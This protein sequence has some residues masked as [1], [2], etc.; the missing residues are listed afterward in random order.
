MA[1]FTHLHLH[2]QYSVLDGANE[3]KSLMKQVK[4]LGMDSVAITDH[5]NMYGV[6]EFHKAAKSND[7][8]P[9]LGCEAYVARRGLQL[10]ETKEDRSGEHII[11]LAKNETGYKN[12]MKIISVS[13][14]EG[15]YYKPR[16]DKELLF[17]HHDGIIVTT[18]CLGG[19]VPQAILKGDTKKAEQIASEYKAVFGDDYYLELQLH[20][21]EIN[22]PDIDTYERQ[23]EVNKVIMDISKK[24]DIKVVATNDVHFLKKEDAKAHNLLVRMNTKKT[25]SE[26]IKM[27]YTG[28]EY[29]KSPEEMAE[30]F[31]DIPE[32]LENTQEIKNKIEDFS[33]DKKPIMPHFE[34]PEGFETEADY[35]RHIVFE[36]A[37]KCWD[38]ITPEIE[39]RLN[40]EL[41][42]IIG[43]GFPGYFLIVW[44]F[45]KAAREMGVWVG[46]G[47]GSAAGSAVAYTLNIITVDPIKYG[48][49]FERFLNPDRISMPDIDID[50]DDDGREKILKW[51]VE[52]YGKERVANII[53]YGT[54]ASKSSIRD[55][56]RVLE[57]PLYD[58]DRLAKLVPDKVKNLEQAYAE[59]EELKTACE[60]S[61]KEAEVLRYAKL[62]EG[63]VRQ[64]GVHACGII[65][66]RDDLVEHIPVSTSKDADLLVTQFEGKHVEDVGLL[67]MDF[68]GLR[69][70]SIMKDAVANIKKQHG[71]DV[72]LASIPLDD[73]EVFALFTR[74][75]TTALFQFESDN[76]KKFLRMLKPTHFEDL[77]AMNA[78]YRPGPMQYIDSF[79]RRK[80]GKEK[81]TYDHPDM[82][83][84]LETTYGITVYQEQVMRLSRKMAGFTRGQADS[85]RKA[86]GKKIVAKMNELRPKFFEGCQKNGYSKELIT[87][88]WESWAEFAKYAFNRSHSVCY[89]YL[90]YQTAYLKAHYPPEF[91]AAALTRN[92]S[93][94]NK[95]QILMEETKRMGLEVNLPD[96]NQGYYD[97]Q[98]TKKG[99]N[100]GL[101]AIKGV[102]KSAVE[103]IVEERNNNGNFKD[104]Y[105]FV[106]R[107]NLNSVNKRTI[108]ALV[109]AGAFD[110][111]SGNIHRSAFFHK[112]HDTSPSFIEDTIRYG[113]SYQ[114]DGDTMQQSIFG[115]S[116]DVEILKP[117]PPEIEPWN[118]LERLNKEK[119]VIG[120]YLSEH[121]LDNYKLE[122]E[123]TC[124]PLAELTTNI[125]KYKGME[126]KTAGI[127]TGV[128]H[129][130]TKNGNPFG[131]FEYEDFSGNFKVTIFGKDYI[132][133]KNYMTKGFQVYIRGK[134]EHRFNKPDAELEY[135]ITKIDMLSE[136]KDKIFNKI[137][138]KLPVEEISGNFVDEFSNFVNT[139]SG[140]VDL[141]VIVYDPKSNVSV[142]MHSRSKKV[143][144]NNKFVNYLKQ[145]TF[146]EF[147][148]S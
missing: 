59:V 129:A 47:R 91:M 61:G 92:I 64:T 125:E 101:G 145:K 39:Q 34:L 9:I 127:I 140:N 66:S 30:L 49:L 106:E 98:V 117:T 121:P 134:V 33:L 6:K 69:T 112:T 11:L 148:I 131:S 85:L 83:E 71:I 115:G 41:D 128:R 29:L 109:L 45:L 80:H 68:L 75:E 97:F 32:A 21:S 74:G 5:G 120:I 70:L 7:I 62:L 107:V 31:P 86:M 46:P 26:K 52:K 43:M 89:A 105:D 114:G 10:K 14:V 60:G 139:N 99:I 24:L 141:D 81:V 111:I 142:K 12:L 126:V 116:N 73:P 94:I 147:L 102:G 18:A 100:F 23:L 95:V 36:G 137:M 79:I 136:V 27:Y 143:N 135:R 130:T 16:I 122:I 90:A 57:F 133:L 119:E 35:L 51:V 96:V 78:L 38:E 56:A 76:M 104:F 132:N 138:V 1:Q 77:V 110:S 118:L 44:D 8:K 146:M 144:L 50:F 87:T 93:E 63:S 123:N 40:F 67:K 28:E 124:I 22:D 37:K 20:K 72:D 84:F 19:T 15:F 48:L 25:I 55:V 17:K 53:T 54:M 42:T 13:H 88:V 4:A 3:I 108:E 65:I 58:A 2:T 82:A 113:N 103:A